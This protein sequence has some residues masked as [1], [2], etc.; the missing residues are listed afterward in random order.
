MYVLSAITHTELVI[1][2]GT[3]KRL[4]KQLWVL[5]SENH[6]GAA[7]CP[8]TDQCVNEAENGMLWRSDFVVG[9]EHQMAF[10]FLKLFDLLK[11]SS[12]DKASRFKF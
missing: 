5:F 10:V 2:P 9:Y 12:P 8:E 6:R 1:A 7:T 3:Q 4:N 11:R